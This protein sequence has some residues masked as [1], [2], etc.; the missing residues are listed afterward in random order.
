MILPDKA[1]TKLAR[2]AHL[3]TVDDI[4]THIPG[5]IWVERYGDEVLNLMKPIDE[6]WVEEHKR[7]KQE[8]KMKRAE[9]TSRRRQTRA[10]E[11]TMQ[12]TH[13]LIEK[14]RKRMEKERKKYDTEGL[15]QSDVFALSDV[16]TCSTLVP[17]QPFNS[18]QLVWSLDTSH[19]TK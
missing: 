10:R 1:L 12:R 5:W 17:S 4:K 18:S 8:K 2:C 6:A 7:E 15:L 14:E 13:N 9:D 16:P 3:Q 19:N 11:K